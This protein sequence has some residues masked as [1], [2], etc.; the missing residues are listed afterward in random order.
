MPKVS[1]LKVVIDT[2]LLISAIITAR[3][4]PDK[5]I[6][7]WKKDIFILL[8]SQQLMSELEEVISRKKF[9]NYHAVFKEKGEELIASLKAAAEAVDPLPVEKLPIHSRDPKDDYLLSASL[10]GKADYLVT[11]DEDLLVLQ[12]NP[13]LGKLQIITIKEFLSKLKP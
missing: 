6:Q 7:I 5:V 10:G 4:N 8:V 1:K 3:S 9:L 2:N 12:T 11:G 13:N